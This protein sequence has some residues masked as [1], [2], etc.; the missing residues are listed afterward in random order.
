MGEIVDFNAFKKNKEEQKRNEIKPKISE[1]DALADVGKKMDA[2]S[3]FAIL[4][5]NPERV[6]LIYEIINSHNR[7]TNPETANTAAETLKFWSKGEIVKFLNEASP[8]DL[9][10]KPT[11][12][13]TAFKKLFDFI[14]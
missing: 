7:V 11:F 5:M 1:A 4:K 13:I 14:E 3:I 10:S 2:N 12:T 6:T 9:K 8:L